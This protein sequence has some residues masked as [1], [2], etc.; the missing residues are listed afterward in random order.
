MA[1]PGLEPGTPRFS[2]VCC[3]FW[4]R[5]ISRVFPRTSNAWAVQIFPVLCGRLLCEKAHGGVRGPFRRAGHV[6]RP[7][8]WCRFLW[9][10]SLVVRPPYAR[11]MATGGRVGDAMVE[12]ARA[13][14]HGRH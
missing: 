8:A 14:H 7:A 3:G 10:P 12:R 6:P 2:V 5:L 1:R 4:V 13:W 11:G 9:R